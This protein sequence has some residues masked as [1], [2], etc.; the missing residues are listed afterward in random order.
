MMK[1]KTSV[2]WLIIMCLFIFK[3]I[4]HLSAQSFNSR[5]DSIAQ[6]H[7]LTG[8]SVVVMCNGQIDRQHHYGLSD[9]GRNIAVNDSTKYRIASIS[10]SVT[11]AGIL[12]LCEQGLCD[13]DRDISQYMGYTI[14]HPAY[15][16][17]SISIRKLLS[18]TSG[19]QDGTGYNSFLASTYGSSNPPDISSLLLPGGSFYSA[20]MWNANAPGSWFQYAN[21]NYGMIASIIEKI[22]STRFDMYIRD[23][24]L[25][26]LGISGSYNVSELPDINQLAVLY[27]NGSAQADNYNGVA[28]PPIQLTAYQPGQ[29]GLYFAPQG[30][31][32]ISVTELFRIMSMF[33]GFGEFNGVRV[34]DS[35]TVSA[36]VQPQWIFNGS[37]G[38]NY[39][40]LF[41]SFGMGLHLSTNSPTGDIVSQQNLM[42]GHPGE[43]YGLISDMY[44]ETAKRYGMIF[45]TN[46]YYGNNNYQVA[47]G[48]AYYEPE[49]AF[50]AL[51]D[52]V[53]WPACAST[54]S[55][56]VPEPVTE[57]QKTPFTFD[58]QTFSFTESG[59]GEITL[60]EVSGRFAA[61][62]NTGNSTRWIESLPRG[63]YIAS[64]E[65]DG[66]VFRKRIALLNH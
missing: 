36:M 49:A 22:T 40:G 56:S 64:M 47:P 39:F 6:A 33:S 57:K 31:L 37:N 35:V 50:F 51:C 15:P 1:I 20:N 29:N 11:A 23:S 66:T 53:T 43:A 38:D 61:I 32:R 10:K 14:R 59:T 27:R 42:A 41:N 13:V 28:P 16:N 21:V 7:S 25:L 26:P 19:M 58:G 2:L 60:Y 48:S 63:I 46:G 34:L 9:I 8:L 4:G 12:R 45:I 62:W 24:V 52:Q 55:V 5:V 54:L 65:K 44:F 30:G 17:D 18:H 3:D